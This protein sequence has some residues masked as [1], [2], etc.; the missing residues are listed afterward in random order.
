MNADQQEEL[1]MEVETLK[2]MIVLAEPCGFPSFEEEQELDEPLTGVLTV[3]GER[4]S[5]RKCR[6][7]GAGRSFLV[8]IGAIGTPRI[9]WMDEA[10]VRKSNELAIE[11]F[12]RKKSRP[13]VSRRRTRKPKRHPA[14]EEGWFLNEKDCSMVSSQEH[15]EI[16]KP[17]PPT[18]GRGGRPS[19]K[20]LNRKQE[21]P[22]NHVNGLQL[23]NAE[24]GTLNQVVDES[25][26]IKVEVALATAMKFR[27][28]SQPNR[29]QKQAVILPEWEVRGNIPTGANSD[30]ASPKSVMSSSILEVNSMFGANC[31]RIRNRLNRYGMARSESESLLPS[32]D[33][34]MEA[35]LSGP[36]NGPLLYQFG[37]SATSVAGSLLGMGK[38]QHANP[39]ALASPQKIRP[40]PLCSIWDRQ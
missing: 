26:P 29:V 19:G 3:L 33:L 7:S 38:R 14:V 36:A 11:V 17:L 21:T 12:E 23:T 4:F 6:R 27:S 31:A 2:A 20:S 8:E 1:L 40:H 15:C 35:A 32:C 13:P 22:I 10:T 5:K 18:G 25:M 34:I 30:D 39:T 28:P 24:P 9:E 16:N 37:Q